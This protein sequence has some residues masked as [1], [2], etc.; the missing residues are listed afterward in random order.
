MGRQEAVTSF[1]ADP[2]FW[3]TFRVI[4]RGIL[5]ALRL[6]VADRQVARQIGE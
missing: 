1:T 4:G 3:A 2:Y 6:H 5:L